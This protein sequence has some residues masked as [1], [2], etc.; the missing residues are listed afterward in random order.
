MARRA[1]RA[2]AA[3]ALR[4][5]AL[6]WWLTPAY[7]DELLIV[8]QD[9]RTLDPSFLSEIAAD[10]FGLAGTVVGL[11]GFSPFALPPP[12][13]DWARELHGFGWLRHLRA[14]NHDDAQAAART[15]ATSW[16]TLERRHADIAIILDE[17]LRFGLELRLWLRRR[18]N[19]GWLIAGAGRRFAGAGRLGHK[20]GL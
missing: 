3:R 19:L 9:L 16:L 2:A 5:P 4:S 18:A 20:V 10:Q 14:A 6:R 8:P 13:D 7:A 11:G 15:F 12:N 1:G 17:D